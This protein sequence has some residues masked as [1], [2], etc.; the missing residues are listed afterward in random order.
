MKK[1]T[2]E[3]YI[4]TVYPRVIIDHIDLQFTYIC[5]YISGFLEN[6]FIL[7]LLT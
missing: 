1:K 3:T 5:A 7:I 4:V 2:S 6:I